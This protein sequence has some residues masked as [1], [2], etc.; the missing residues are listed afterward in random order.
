MRQQGAFRDKRMSYDTVNLWK[1][2]RYHVEIIKI[3]ITVLIIHR[4]CVR[5]RLTFA[6]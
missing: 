4:I 3:E 1:W 2:T 5:V 6:L